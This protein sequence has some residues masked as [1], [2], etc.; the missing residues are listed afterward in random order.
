MPGATLTSPRLRKV[1]SVAAAGVKQLAYN[2]SHCSYQPG[3]SGACLSF[4]CVSGTDSY[5]VNVAVAVG[6][7]IW[8]H[9]NIV[10]A[11]WEL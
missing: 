10:I 6:G 5:D 11:L 8:R 3:Q 1:G 2:S 9:V 7:L 4:G